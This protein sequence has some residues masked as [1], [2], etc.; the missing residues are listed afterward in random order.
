VLSGGSPALAQFGDTSEN[1]SNPFEP[2]VMDAGCTRSW[3]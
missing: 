3:E 2:S 1:P